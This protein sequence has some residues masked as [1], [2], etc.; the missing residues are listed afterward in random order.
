MKLRDRQKSRTRERLMAVAFDLFSRRGI[1]VTTTVEVARGAGVSHGTVFAHFRTKE[2]LVVSVIQRYTTR[3]VERIHERAGSG[4][5][6]E[7]VLAAHLAGLAR[8][9]RFYARLVAEGAS[10]PQRARTTLLGIQ[11]A[12]SFH[13]AAAAEREMEAGRIKRIPVHLLFNTWLGLIHHYLVNRD[14]FACGESV[15]AERGGELVDHFM[16][17]LRPA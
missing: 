6:L 2:E 5:G 9:E 10:L 11:S 12:I 13:L 15:L 8:Y 7:G 4:A 1:G 3:V 14:L 16:G 17:L